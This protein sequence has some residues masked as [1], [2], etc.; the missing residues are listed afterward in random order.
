M[1]SRPAL[2]LHIVR[3]RR[4]GQPDRWYI[5]A[6]RGGP[7]IHATDGARPRITAE[8]TDK[9]AEA[10][11]THQRT[12]H[13][14]F[15]RVIEDY[16][17]SPDYTSLR[18]TT[19]DDTGRWLDRIQDEFGTAPLAAFEDRKMRGVIIQWSD[20]WAHQPRTADKA[21]GYM[22][23]L[24]GWAVERGR[25]SINVAAGIRKRYK[26][27]RAHIIWTEADLAALRAVASPPVMQAVELASLT[28]LRRADLVAVT[29]EAVGPQMIVWKTS[30]SRGRARVTIPLLPE[31]RKLLDTLRTERGPGGCTGPILR[32]SRGQ[33]WKGD[34]LASSFD[35]ART[36]CEISKRLHD[37]RGTYATRLILAGLTDEEAARIMGWTSADIAQ[38]RARYV[39]E[40]RVVSSI[41]DRL[42]CKPAVNRPN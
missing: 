5:Y 14:A 27:S 1:K 3:K 29:W 9:L 33:P 39:D 18:P 20:Q 12:A 16:R 21:T 38:I 19:R 24:L 25:L 31:L 4:T 7:R 17:A 6:W 35:R 42:S 34:G 13:G 26:V 32:N 41:I 11:R 30:K 22:G 37:L 8:I 10:R 40:M 23:Q 36:R 2:G 28:G 15:A